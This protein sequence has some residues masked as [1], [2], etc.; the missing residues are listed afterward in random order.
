MALVFLGLVLIPYHEMIWPKY[1][2]SSP[3]KTH[4]LLFAYNQFATHRQKFIVPFMSS[5]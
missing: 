2:T 5:K 3:P 4:L 1:S